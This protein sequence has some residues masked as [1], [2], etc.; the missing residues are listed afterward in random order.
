MIDWPTP[1][2]NIVAAS[3]LS[4]NFARLGDE[5]GAVTAAGAEWIHVD[6][7]DG[8]FVPNL[9]IGVPIVN[10]LR[11]VTR[12]PLDVHLMI[13]HPERLLGAFAQAGADVMTVHAEA[14]PHLH[15]VLGQI[16]DLGCRAGVALNPATPLSA[17]DYV[18]DLVD[19]VLVMSVNPG[20]SG[21]RFI[22]STLPKLMALQDAVRAHRA[23]GRAIVVEVDGG[24][25]PENAGAARQAGVDVS[26]GQRHLWQPRL[27]H[28][29]P[30]LVVE[31]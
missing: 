13:E 3:I 25:G 7:M 9:S 2:A 24:I 1:P 12:A 6:V 4:A 23:R 17:L 15:R 20:F 18:W 21:Q 10:S 19:L 5:V 22:P 8:S 27:C 16:H 11:P 28:G 14:C 29:H 31:L 30:G 26:S